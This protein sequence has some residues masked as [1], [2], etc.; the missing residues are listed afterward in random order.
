[1]QGHRVSCSIHSEPAEIGLV[2]ALLEEYRLPAIAAG[3]H[4][5]EEPWTEHPW[6]SSHAALAELVPAPKAAR[7]QSK[8]RP[9]PEV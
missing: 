8:L 5:V 1:M 9:D 4:V 2:V 3:D 7:G 6:R